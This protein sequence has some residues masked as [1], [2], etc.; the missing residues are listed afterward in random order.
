MKFKPLWRIS[1][2]TTLEAEDAVM[3]QL[4]DLLECAAVAYFDAQAVVSTVSV[5][6]ETAPAKDLRKQIA[7]ILMRVKSCGLSIKPGK[8]SIAK[9]RPADWAESWKRH[10]QPVEF[11]SRLLVKPGWS[12]RRPKKHQAVVILDPGLSF[13]TGQHPTTAF[14]L[15]EIVQWSAFS[16]SASGERKGKPAGRPRSSFLDVGTGS[17][18]LAI[19]AAKLGYW[20]VAAFDFDPIAMEIARG[21]ARKNSVGGKIRFRR[22]DAAKLSLRP[23]RHYDLVCANLSREVLVAQR[24]RIAAQL[25]RTGTLVL[26]GIMKWEFPAVET[27]FAGLGWRRVSA[28]TEKEWRSGAFRF[29][30]Q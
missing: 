17:G 18:I 7:A 3:E 8:I 16:P 21:N 9:L 15:R 11:G 5:F 20:P 13:G 28:R 24:R 6:A 29:E 12:R 4:G 30:E 19:A 26:A 27:S 1:V 25:K 22:G 23:A 10:F 14:C 2:A